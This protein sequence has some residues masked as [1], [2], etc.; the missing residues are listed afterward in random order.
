MWL[1]KYPKLKNVVILFINRENL[2]LLEI[3]DAYKAFRKGQYN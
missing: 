2:Q 1:N 3:G